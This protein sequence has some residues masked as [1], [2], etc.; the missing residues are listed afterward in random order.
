[1][2]VYIAGRIGYERTRFG[3]PVDIYRHEDEYW[4]TDYPT[5][6]FRS[7]TLT[8]TG[9]FTV[10]C[11]HGCAHQFKHAVGPTCGN[12]SM[13]LGPDEKIEGYHFQKALRDLVVRKT[14]QGIKDADAVFVWLSDN[15]EIAHGTLTEIGYAAA[16]Q[17]PIYI[18]C[19]SKDSDQT[20]YAKSLATRNYCANNL[21][22]KTFFAWA[23]SD[24][25]TFVRPACK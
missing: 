11:D 8:Y 3:L 24:H 21:E 22:F 25:L 13:Y 4:I 5:F 14:T 7:H 15:S 19:T 16:L 6:V 10:S 23:L 12:D 1:M 18:G 20:W 17:K 2:N 9:P